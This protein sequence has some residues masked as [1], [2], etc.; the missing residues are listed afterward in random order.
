MHGFEDDGDV[1]FL[2]TAVAVIHRLVLGVG[3]AGEVRVAG[4]GEGLLH[5]RVEFELVAFD[6]EEIVALFVAD[7]QAIGGR[8]AGRVD[9][10][11][12]PREVERV[13]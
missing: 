5:G 1:P 7:L 10:D 12:G 3:D 8:T 13:K 4:V 2:V 6:G 11:E 9:G